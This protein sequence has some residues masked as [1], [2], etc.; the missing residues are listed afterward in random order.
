MKARL[1]FPKTLRDYQ[2][3]AALKALASPRGMV[4][5]PTG[6]GK[7]LIGS[8]IAYNYAY[9]LGKRVAVLVPTKVLADQWEAHFKKWWGVRIGVVHSER[10]E[11]R[12]ITVWVYNSFIRAAMVSKKP[13]A[14]V[15]IV[16]EVHHA[17]ARML[18]LALRAHEGAKIIGLTATP[19][20]W[21][22]QAELLALIPI[23]YKLSPGAA[24]E[25][26]ALVQLELKPIGVELEPELAREYA[27]IDY[28]VSRL[29]RMVSEEDEGAAELKERLV[30]LIQKRKLIAARS[31]RKM[32]IAVELIKR[33]ALSGRVLVFTESADVARKLA[34][35][36]GG[37]AILAT[38]PKSQRQ[39]LIAEWGRT[40]NVLV[41]C[42]VLEEGFDVPECGQGVIVA[43]GTGDRQLIQRVGRLVR[44]APGKEKAVIYFVYA[45]GTHE[46]K[47]LAKLK[48]MFGRDSGR[49][50]EFF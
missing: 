16:D 14:D 18:M 47:A 23:V 3:E 31:P 45:K 28:Q 35:R 7:T 11:V 37:A 42:K 2:R 34:S 27:E 48:R 10:R 13:L 32:E 25:R 41:S 20:R 29:M 9:V 43:T 21:D 5:L 33:L 38:T 15:I 44:P 17:G 22:R 12:E 19:T 4:V 26:G 24:L 40:F 36:T 49:I 46:E 1:L 50:H 8:T 30:K 6:T 39:R